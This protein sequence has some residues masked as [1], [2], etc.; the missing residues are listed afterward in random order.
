MQFTCV[1]FSLRC[2]TNTA[3][4]I[5]CPREQTAT[6]TLRSTRNIVAYLQ[7]VYR[8]VKAHRTVNAVILIS[9]AT[10]KLARGAAA[11][12]A[13]RV[14]TAADADRRRLVNDRAADRLARRR[15]TGATAAEEVRM[16]RPPREPVMVHQDRRKGRRLP[17]ATNG[18]M[19][20]VIRHRVRGRRSESN[21]DV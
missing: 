2:F 5:T 1:E 3:L 11:R 17:G 9:R 7:R 21:A 10:S 19:P 18:Q 20:T 14:Q 16:P 6:P 8:L 15:L 13:A 12:A 4:K